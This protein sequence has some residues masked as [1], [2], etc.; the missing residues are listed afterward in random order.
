MHLRLDNVL[1]MI[2]QNRVESVILF[3]GAYII[4]VTLTVAVSTVTYKFIEVPFQ[5]IG[6]KIIKRIECKYAN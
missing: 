5:V 4:I 6:K 3:V 2:H 1:A